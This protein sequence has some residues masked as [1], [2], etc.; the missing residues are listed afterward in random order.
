MPLPVS[1]TSRTSQS[2]CSVSRQSGAGACGKT[3]EVAGGNRKIAA[4]GQGIAGING[5]IG[6]D[7]FE[8]RRIGEQPGASGAMRECLLNVGAEETREHELALGQDFVQIHGLCVEHL[9]AAEGRMT[10]CFDGQRR[11]GGFW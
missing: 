1:V 7:L 11:A 5:E 4:E 8:L 2:C 3:A 10:E 9:L 6:D